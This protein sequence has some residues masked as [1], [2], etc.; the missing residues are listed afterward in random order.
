LSTWQ[1]QAA[2]FPDA[3]K[4]NSLE[5]KLLPSTKFAVCTGCTGRQNPFDAA[6][7]MT[8]PEPDTQIRAHDI[9]RPRAQHP[10][11]RKETRK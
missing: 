5:P 4:S 11:L 8:V 7:Q 10:T 1:G 9:K 6:L 3:L 2:R